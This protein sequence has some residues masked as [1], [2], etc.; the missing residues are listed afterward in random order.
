MQRESHLISSHLKPNPSRLLRTLELELRRLA[1]LTSSGSAGFRPL[2]RANRFMTSVS[3]MTPTKRPDKR[4]PELYGML[5][6]EML[7]WWCGD[8]VEG[9][10]GVFGEAGVFIIDGGNCVK[11]DDDVV[12]AL[13]RIGVP[14]GGEIVGGEAVIGGG[15]D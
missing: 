2:A 11:A 1:F 8:A 14:L 3:V 10:W 15:M 5:A 6:A 12:D 13:E 4:P 7:E 9:R